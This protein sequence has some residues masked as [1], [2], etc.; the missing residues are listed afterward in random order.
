VGRRPLSRLPLV[1]PLALLAACATLARQPISDDARRAVTLLTTRA[2]EFTD[3]RALADI[4]VK[5]GT[6]RLRL[7]GVLL[8]K[9]P[10]SI[11]FEV[12]SPL[13]PP[14]RVV[15]VHDGKLT[16]YDAL[17]NEAQ[18]GPATA[19][20]IE[21]ALR[22]PLTPEDL[23]AALAGRIAPP[24]DLKSAQLKPPDE[25]GPSIE[26]VSQA[27]R[28]RVW[29]DLETGT[30]RQLE[31]YGSPFNALVTYRRDAGGVLTGF[32]V[33][34][35]QSYVTGSVTYQNLVEGSGIEAERFTMA[36][37]KGAKIQDIR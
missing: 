10:A 19:E 33:E 28:R 11:R 1:A 15:T 2:N 26:L 12:L 5:R 18:I 36:I 29:L 6:E 8:A 21:K 35:A 17:K 24:S 20:T 14:L 16:V 23:V 9:A 31:I 3:L 7:Q 34:A 13:G 30:V 27:G 32:E 25:A 4:A 37:P 22:L